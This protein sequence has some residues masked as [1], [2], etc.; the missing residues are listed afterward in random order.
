[1]TMEG[2]GFPQTSGRRPLGFT[3]IELMIVVTVVAILAF[4]ALPSYQSAIRKSNR[5]EMQAVMQAMAQ[6]E[7]KIFADTRGYVSCASLTACATSLGVNAL[8]KTNNNYTLAVTLPAGGALG[9][10]ITATPKAGTVQVSD[11]VLSLNDRGTKSPS[12]LW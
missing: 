4:V 3:L 1:M 8:G 5:A 12:G 2:K 11:P 6:E 10:T 7:L 9:Y